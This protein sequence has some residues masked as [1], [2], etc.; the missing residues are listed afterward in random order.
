MEIFFGILFCAIEISGVILILKNID[1]FKYEILSPIGEWILSLFSKK[2]GKPEIESKPFTVSEYLDRIEKAALDIL[3]TH[4]PED[5]TITLWWGFDG[6]R[7]SEDGTAEW[8][9]RRKPEP[10]NQG[11]F[12]QPQQVMA[13]VAYPISHYGMDMCQSTQATID[14]LQAQIAMQ[15][16]NARL[17][18]QLQAY[19]VSYPAYY[20]PYFYGQTYPTNWPQMQNCCCAFTFSDSF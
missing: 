16:V 8:I 14:A 7:I 3:D 12:C 13:Q 5:R 11:V 4:K 18:G 19:Q 2:S 15:N 9:S 17:Q 1:F 20:P 10:V 6:L